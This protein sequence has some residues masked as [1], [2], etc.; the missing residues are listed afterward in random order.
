M[1]KKFLFEDTFLGKNDSSLKNDEKKLLKKKAMILM[2]KQI[3][4]AN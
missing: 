3:G 1:L 4:F 2:L